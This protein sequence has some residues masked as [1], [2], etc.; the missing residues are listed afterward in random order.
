MLIDL[1]SPEAEPHIVK[2]VYEGTGSPWRWTGSE[3]TLK[4]LTFKTAHVKLSADF[5]LWDEAFRQTGPV[6]LE[7]LVNGK[8]LD[9]IRYATPGPK[10]FEKPVRQ[11]WLNTDVESTILVKID[12]LYV[13]P[14]DGKKF[15]IILSSIGF[16]E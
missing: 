3:P 4:V 5:T 7:F 2:D 13:S 11:D 8:S 9:R 1:A 12:K 10:H 16:V 15:G 6:E 14:H